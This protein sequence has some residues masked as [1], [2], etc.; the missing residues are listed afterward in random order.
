MASN[1]NQT[2]SVKAVVGVEFLAHA[3]S[4]TIQNSVTLKELAPS[5]YFSILKEHLVDIKVSEK[6]DEFQ[7]LH[8]R[9]IKE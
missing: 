5:P 2:L 7:S 3:L 4:S 1:F 8:F 6:F 9:D